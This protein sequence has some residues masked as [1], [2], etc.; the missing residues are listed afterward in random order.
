MYSL[1]YLLQE[2]EF[3]KCG[4]NVFKIG[5]SRQEYFKRINSYPIGSK[6]LMIIEC[7]DCDKCESDLIAI[8]KKKFIQKIYGREY[9]EG[10]P[11][12][13]RMAFLN[14]FEV[15]FA[16]SENLTFP[17][18]NINFDLNQE[19]KKCDNVPVGLSAEN[20]TIACQKNIKNS[21]RREKNNKNTNDN[22]TDD[23]SIE[24]N[25][26]NDNSSAD[27]NALTI[28]KNDFTN[29]TNEIIFFEETNF[30]CFTCSKDC[31]SKTTLWRHMKT[32][33]LTLSQTNKEEIAI[34]EEKSMKQ[35]RNCGLCQFSTSSES[36][37][38]KHLLSSTHIQI[39]FLNANGDYNCE[40]CGFSTKKLF[41]FKMHLRSQKHTKTDEIKTYICNICNKDCKSYN[42]KW[43]HKQKCGKQECKPQKISDN[44][45]LDKTT[46]ISSIEKTREEVKT[47]LREFF[48]NSKPAAFSFQKFFVN[49]CKN[50]I[51]FD[52][53][54]ENYCHISEKQIGL[55]CKE[56]FTEGITQIILKSLNELGV[57]RRPI[58]CTDTKR[59]TIYV[60][61]NGLWDKQINKDI[62]ISFINN[63]GESTK[64]IITTWQRSYNECKNEKTVA[65]DLFDEA[66]R[67]RLADEPDVNIDKIMKNIIG[68]VGID[69]SLYIAAK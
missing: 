3:V 13:I 33:K 24:D 64:E 61:I 44:S 47:V 2:R 53:L 48:E 17:V 11:N 35:K 37:F 23:N 27:S 52:D 41:N 57:Q 21:K 8:F 50:S 4:E 62:L 31:Y 59:Q 66:L 43:R 15:H 22:N 30:V 9:F 28:F 32:C 60:K 14:Y 26:I 63:I 12:E 10:K 69:K 55:I 1:C 56:G 45:I 19:I 51:N 42:S 40:K 36:L 67:K 6:V 16:N 39:F 65:V 46:I 34:T 58:H 54:L 68:E 29:S 18:G 20:I 38:E 5:K 7:D 25:V 49:V